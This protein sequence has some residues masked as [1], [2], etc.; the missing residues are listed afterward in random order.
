M[1]VQQA[2][3]CENIPDC[4]TFRSANYPGCMFSAADAVRRC[5]GDGP[6]SRVSPRQA[7]GS[8]ELGVQGTRA[9][10]AD[11]HQSI[12][13]MAAEAVG[14]DKGAAESQKGE[15]VGAIAMLEAGVGCGFLGNSGQTMIERQ[16]QSG[17]W[18]GLAATRLRAAPP[19]ACTHNGLNLHYPQLSP[20]GNNTAVIIRVTCHI[21]HSEIFKLRTETCLN[22]SRRD[23]MSVNAQPAHLTLPTRQTAC[24]VLCKRYALRTLH[25]YG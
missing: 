13:H 14:R 25:W 7:Q 9:G 2:Q 3:A 11:V 21:S 1:L 6:G 24:P 4:Y 17:S 8:A 18:H 12:I 20:T 10:G 16:R 15:R 19:P 22:S 23:T 5:G